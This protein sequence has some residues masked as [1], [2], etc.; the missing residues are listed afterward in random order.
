MILFS[1]FSVTNVGFR[2]LV[3]VIFFGLRDISL[4]IFYRMMTVS[5]NG[6]Y[7]QGVASYMEYKK[8]YL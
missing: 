3:N 1:L 7:I 4:L 6:L 2:I 8:C 5:K